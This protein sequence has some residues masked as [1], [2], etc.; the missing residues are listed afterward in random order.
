MLKKVQGVLGLGFRDAGATE[1]RAHSGLFGFGI[2]GPGC[3]I[4]G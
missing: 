3:R 4:Q 2:M 1:S